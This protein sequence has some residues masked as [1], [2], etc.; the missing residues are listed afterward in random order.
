MVLCDYDSTCS[1]T[2]LRLYVHLYS[3]ITSCIVADTLRLFHG[4]V[5]P[6]FN[7]FRFTITYMSTSLSRH[8]IIFFDGRKPEAFHWLCKVYTHETMSDWTMLV[9]VFKREYYS[10]MYVVTRRVDC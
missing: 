1:N 4:I 5:C 8:H 10:P 7:V 2:W 9:F 3:V 6:Y